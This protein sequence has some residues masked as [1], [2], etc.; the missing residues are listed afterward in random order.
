L[1]EVLLLLRAS[2]AARA[3]LHVAEAE[4]GLRAPRFV[5]RT[6][7][8]V[9]GLLVALLGFGLLAAFLVRVG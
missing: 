5:S 8:V 2:M 4:S 9:L 3:R 6:W 7:T 1:L